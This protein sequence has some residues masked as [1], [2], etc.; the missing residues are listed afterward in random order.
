MALKA[1][2]DP[3]LIKERRQVIMKVIR[4]ALRG[5]FHPG[6]TYRGY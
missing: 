4:T 1:A 3:M 5:I 6:L 2:V